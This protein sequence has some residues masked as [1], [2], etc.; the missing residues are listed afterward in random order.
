MLRL[1]T[2]YAA[3]A[4]NYAFGLYVFA[5]AKVAVQEIEAE[6]FVGFG[7]LTFGLAAILQAMRFPRMEYLFDGEI[8]RSPPTI[9]PSQAAVLP[10]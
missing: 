4:I 10:Q 2:L 6:L 5:N 8:S 7:T 9:S 1:C 3:A